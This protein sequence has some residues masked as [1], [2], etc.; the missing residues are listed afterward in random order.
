MLIQER[1]LKDVEI[2]DLKVVT[3]KQPTEAELKELM[4]AWRD[5]C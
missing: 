5:L 4:F 2:K 1:D 3:K